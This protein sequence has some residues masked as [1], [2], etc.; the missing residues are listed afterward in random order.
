[1]AYGY[2]IG[3]L[4]LT[5]VQRLPS[6]L[7]LVREMQRAGREVVSSARL[8]EL[9]GLEAVQVRKDFGFI[10]ISGLPKLGYPVEELV[11]AI[12]RCLHW[13]QVRDAVL[14]GVGHL[15]RALL[16]YEGFRAHGLDLCAAF[17]HDPALAG[18]VV[19]RTPVWPMDQLEP[20]LRR[21]DARMA[22]LTVSPDAA[23]DVALRLVRAGIEGIWNFTGC[24]LDLP[25]P[26]IVQDQDLAI[27]LAVLSAKLSSRT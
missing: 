12:E 21:L 25:A 23:K 2:K 8:G 1:V 19:N 6:Y 26:I 17:D 24:A 13:N 14:V 20:E 3:S 11:R 7:R 5:T 10:G 16:G 4:P 22:I 9:L 18:L 27:G 15:G